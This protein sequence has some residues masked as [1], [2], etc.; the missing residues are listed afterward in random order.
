[1]ASEI[2]GGWRENSGGENNRMQIQAREIVILSSF[3]L[4]VFLTEDQAS[5][6]SR[7]KRVFHYFVRSSFCLLYQRQN[8]KTE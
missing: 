5:A 6:I 4:P 8:L 7:F 3:I 2:V 1:M